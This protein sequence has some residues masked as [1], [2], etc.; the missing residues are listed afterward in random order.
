MIKRVTI[1]LLMLIAAAAMQARDFDD[2]KSAMRLIDSG[3]DSIAGVMQRLKASEMR[4]RDADPVKAAIYQTLLA[5]L[6]PDDSVPYRSL[7]MSHADLLAQAKATKFKDVVQRLPMGRYFGDDLLSVVGYE[8]EE[9][10]TLHDYYDRHGNRPATML[11]ALQLLEAQRVTRPQYIASLDSLMGIYGDLEVS[12]EVA[13]ARY[14]AMKHDYSVKEKGEYLEKALSKYERYWRVGALKDA[15][16]TLCQ[17]HLEVRFQRSLTTSADSLTFITNTCN[18]RRIDVDIYSTNMPPTEVQ[19]AWRVDDD[20]INEYKKEYSFKHIKHD[21]LAINNANRYETFTH[22]HILPPM[23]KGVYLLRFKTTPPIDD[24]LY[25][26]QCVS[27]L[28]TLSLNMTNGKQLVTVVNAISGK[29]V[30]HAQLYDDDFEKLLATTNAQGEALVDDNLDVCP[31]TA[32]D[33]F[34]YATITRNR[35]SD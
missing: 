15:F 12:A 20:D 24:N 25:V 2:I 18:I 32:D 13:L 17:S 34:C 10:A 33:R 11:T 29:P 35:S 23:D 14:Q 26:F 7:A 16:N 3:K 8:L 19:D 22:G 5:H 4:L 30:P 27:D 6:Q 1:I 9:Y 21:V 28:R 31:A